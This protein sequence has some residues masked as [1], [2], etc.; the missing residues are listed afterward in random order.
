MRGAFV[1]LVVAAAILGTSTAGTVA[2]AG[3][4]TTAATSTATKTVT[5]T[6][7]ITTSGC[8]VHLW[9][10]KPATLTVQRSTKVVWKNMTL[11]PHDVVP[12]TKAACKVSAGTGTDKKFSSPIINPKKTYTFTF[13]H[14]GTYVY[15]CLWHGYAVMHGTII[16]H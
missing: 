11:V 10:Y 8:G 3:S 6:V 9:C 14:P 5:K 16:V 13:V 12:C 7:T 15:Y 4:A 2:V 1:R